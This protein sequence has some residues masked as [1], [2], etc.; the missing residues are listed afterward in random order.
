MK[1]IITAGGTAGHINP[2][3]ALA[4][5]L[6]SRGHDVVFAGTPNRLEAKLVPSAGF[7]FKSFQTY[8]FNRKHPFSLF[9]ALLSIIKATSQAKTWMKEYK[10]NAVVGFG[11]YVSLAICRAAFKLNIPVYIHEQNSVMGMANKYLSKK[12]ECTCLSYNH[13]KTG[14]EKRVVVTGNPVRR[15]ILNFTKKEGREY[16][17]VPYN[18]TLLVV[19][20]GS[21]GASSINESI[22]N[23]AGKLL[24]QNNLYIVHVTGSKE[25]KKC[26]DL[27]KQKHLAS[28]KYKLIEYENQM[29]KVLTA[30]DC[31]ISRAGASSLAEIQ[32]LCVPALLIPYPNAT[33]NHQYY[34]AKEWVEEG[35]AVMLDDSKLGSD[36]FKKLVLRL[37]SN[38]CFRKKLKECAKKQK[39][40]NSTSLLADVV[41]GKYNSI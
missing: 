36:E 41:E 12:A 28:E 24:E 32:A 1:F 23:F 4:E 26:C 8:G 29:G 35:C 39:M 13:A 25:Y 6:K 20:G 21:L 30:A 11:C 2:A 27:V 3:L 5:E 9:K 22:I 10:P 38:S 34:N 15:S 37:T 17:N 31:V 14:N 16:L 19:F 40:K 18:S 7:N 33:E